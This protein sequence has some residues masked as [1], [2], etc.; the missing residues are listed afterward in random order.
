M[1]LCV[2]LYDENPVHPLVMAANREERYD[3][4]SLPPAWIARGPA[5]FAA[6]DQQAG[7]TWQGVNPFGLLVA[8][9]NRATLVREDPDRRSRGRLCLD[10]LGRVSARAAVKWLREHLAGYSYN[11]CN[12]ICADVEEAFAVHHDSAATQVRKLAPG[13][14]LLAE[15]D[16]DDPHHPR[17]L[18]ARYLLEGKTRQDWPVLQRTLAQIMAD[19]AHGHPPEQSICRHGEVAG[20]VSSSLI[21]L[22][23][24]GLEEAQFFFAPGPPCTYPYEDLSAKLSSHP[25]EQP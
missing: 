2:L 17:L 22:R 7:G 5:V 3:R 21:A 18:R 13:L 9:T 11:P 6:Q 25:S 10:T 1:C 23:R 8:L 4:P 16:A 14:H 20:T 12:L 19:H 24:A 15:T